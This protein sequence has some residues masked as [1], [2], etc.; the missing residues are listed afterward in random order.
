MH[1]ALKLFIF[2]ARKDKEE[3]EGVPGGWWA[4][5]GLFMAPKKIQANLEPAWCP[6]GCQ[7]LFTDSAGN[8]SWAAKAHS[9]G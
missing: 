2:Q 7:G 3:V 4:I 5:P 1:A 9:E 8:C 6:P